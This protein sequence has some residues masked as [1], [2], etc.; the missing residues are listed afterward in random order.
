MAKTGHLK[1]G[2]AQII[3]RGCEAPKL[4]KQLHLVVLSVDGLGSFMLN[5]TNKTLDKCFFFLAQT[6]KWLCFLVT[7]SLRICDVTSMDYH[8]QEIVIS[9]MV[10][11]LGFLLKPFR[12]TRKAGF[13]ARGRNMEG[14]TQETLEV[15]CSAYG[16]SAGEPKDLPPVKPLLNLTSII[17]EGGCGKV[18]LTV[19]SCIVIIILEKERQQRSQLCHRRFS[20]SESLPQ[21]GPC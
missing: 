4:R 9:V 3:S 1:V 20:H 18:K 14:R 6:Q 15:R 16:R 11:P 2:P 5:K 12:V 10:I 13:V 8:V 19:E 17:G 21:D 7:Y